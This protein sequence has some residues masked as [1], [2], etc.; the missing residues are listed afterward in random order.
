MTECE[1]HSLTPRGK[2]ISYL[3]TCKIIS[4]GCLY[5]L[6]R[7]KDSNT[8][9]PSLQSI[10]I[11]NEFPE[12]FL[13]D[14]PMIPPDREIYFGLDLFSDTHPIFILPYRM[15]PAELKEFEKATS[16]SP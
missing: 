11:V 9:S 2:L 12:V 15:V 13:N 3:R 5:H 10:P 1:G 4:K 8:E 6:I 14:L 16:R 7:V